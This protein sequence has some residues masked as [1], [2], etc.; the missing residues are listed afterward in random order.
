MILDR[1]DESRSASSRI[2]RF[3]LL[4]DEEQVTALKL[5]EMQRHAMLMYTSCGWFFDD[6]PDLRPCR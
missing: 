5:L 4:N 2:M 3:A 6:S 1:S